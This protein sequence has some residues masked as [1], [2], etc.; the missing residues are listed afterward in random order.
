MDYYRIR[1][2]YKI[3]IIEKAFENILEKGTNYFRQENIYSDYN[4]SLTDLKESDLDKKIIK[5]CIELANSFTSNELLQIINNELSIMTARK[6]YDMHFYERD[7]ETVISIGFCNKNVLINDLFSLYD[8]SIEWLKTMMPIN[9]VIRGLG[10][11]NLI[12]DYRIT[13][14]NGEIYYNVDDFYYSQFEEDEM[15]ME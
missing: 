4:N 7:K 15:E 2:K 9:E 10:I 13:A 3:G 8:E 6:E 12:D 1:S 14:P 5:C 11:D